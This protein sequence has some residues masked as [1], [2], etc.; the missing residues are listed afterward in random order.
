MF[1]IFRVIS[2]ALRN[3]IVTLRDS[4]STVSGSLNTN[5]EIILSLLP[6]QRYF[7]NTR[8][9]LFWNDNV[10]ACLQ[11]IFCGQYKKLN[12]Q[13][14]ENIGG[15]DDNYNNNTNNNDNGVN[16]NNYKNSR[17]YQKSDDINRNNDNMGDENIE[18]EI[19]TFSD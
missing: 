10:K 19:D 3:Q 6:Y 16:F 14:D 4:I 11:M 1:L 5:S 9:E 17:K 15:D 8:S 7:Y 13:K 12:F 18:E 2:S